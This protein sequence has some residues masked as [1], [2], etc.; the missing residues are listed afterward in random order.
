MR[1]TKIYFDLDGV[2]ADFQKGVVELCGIE[3]VDQSHKRSG[4]DDLLFGAMKRVPHFYDR[5]VLMPGPGD[6]LI[7]CFPDLCYTRNNTHKIRRRL[8]NENSA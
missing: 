6:I 4:Q 3:P 2:L 1:A 8:Q 5:L 7:D